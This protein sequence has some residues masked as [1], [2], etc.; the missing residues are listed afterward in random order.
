MIGRGRRLPL[1]EFVVLMAGLFSMVAFS[2]DAM[3]PALPDIAR[4]LSPDAPNRAQLVLSSFI[5]GMG[6]GMLLAG[7]LADRFGRKPV[8]TAG[9]VLYV[10]G[11][12]LAICAVTIEGLLVARLIQGLGMAGPR[13]AGQALLR[14]A[15][16][17]RRMAQICSFIM[18]VFV[19]VPAMAPY[20]GAQIADMAGWR[21]IFGS[22][23][24]I[25]LMMATWLNLRQPETLPRAH[26]R[27]IRLRVIAEALSE[28]GRDRLVMIYVL[29][30]SLCFGML[31]AM[32]SSIQQLYAV[33][34]G[35]ED[36]FPFWFML[37]GLISGLATLFNAALVMRRGMRRL[38]LFAFGAQSFVSAI[39][40]GGLLTIGGDLPFP[41]FFVWT[42]SIHAM[43]ALTFGN[44]TALAL[45]P[46]GHIA[47]I[48]ASVV[49]AVTAF[50]GIMI[51]IPLGLA[52]DG[53]PLPLL[54][55]TM[56]CSAL[57]Y[58]FLRV[59]K[60]IDPDPKTDRPVVTLASRTESA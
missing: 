54:L 30:L 5:I 45:E 37:S 49:N 9:I 59:A 47:G 31:I 26:R 11:A 3:L 57:A 32:L 42:V 35:M 18:M 16:S 40:V 41:A 46:M 36:S 19:I 21:G 28:I 33:T 53:T 10:L 34:Y 20:I 4:E 23:V 29:V 55:G 13:I 25:G 60:A 44:L 51:A 6:V 17:G 27:P 2:I 22:F 15:Y 12:L 39:F 52:F 48:A 58:A 43:A 56:T 1:P 38:A 8:I 7:P 50:G 14:D 24:L